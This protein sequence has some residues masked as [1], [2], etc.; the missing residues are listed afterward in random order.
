MVALALTTGTSC[1]SRVSRSGD[2]NGGPLRRK[3]NILEVDDFIVPSSPAYGNENSDGA[4]PTTSAAR[5]S[6]TS[7]SLKKERRLNN[8]QARYSSARSQIRSSAAGKKAGGVGD[9]SDPN[10]DRFLFNVWEDF[11]LHSVQGIGSM[12]MPSGG[13][14]AGGGPKGGGGGNGPGSGGNGGG[15]GGSG[16]NNGGGNNGGTSPSSPTPSDPG[17]SPTPPSSVTNPLPAPT[18]GGNGGSPS[19]PECE[20]LSREEAYQLVLLAV[21]DG[22]VLANPTTPQGMALRFLLNDDSAQLDPCEVPTIVQRYALATFYFSTDGEDWEN[23]DRWLSSS[24]E[25]N[26]HGITC[27]GGSVTDIDLCK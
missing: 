16:N 21:T 12:S 25:C 10:V 14:G 8:A 5:G 1:A 4:D 17:P 2:N 6:M 7:G 20:S 9:G 24:D 27:N 26:W 15:N 19:P 22:P 3:R 23:N 13:G 18:N 11:V